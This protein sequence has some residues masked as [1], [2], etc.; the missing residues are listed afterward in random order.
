MTAGGTGFGVRTLA[1]LD[2]A[3][4][5]ATR[6]LA[7]DTTLSRLFAIGR[8]GWAGSRSEHGIRMLLQTVVRI[9]GFPHRV[10]S[11]L[12]MTPGVWVA[13]AASDE[14]GADLS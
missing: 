13:S 6:P 5:G 1:R 3:L 4:R 10:R 8:S 12:G 7:T 9:S 11:T 2:A 14:L